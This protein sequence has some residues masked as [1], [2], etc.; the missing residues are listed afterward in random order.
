MD[1][2]DKPY[3]EADDVLALNFI[4]DP[5]RYAFRRY[6]RTGLRSHI[7]EVLRPEDLERE[8]QGVLK[9]KN[10]HFPRAVSLKMLRIFRARFRD[11]QEALDE[12]GRVK[13]I[14]RYLA[15]NHVARSD[16]FLVSYVRGDQADIVLCGLQDYVEG[17]I[18]DPWGPLD[19][20]ILGELLTRMN[21]VETQ[22]QAAI[23]SEKVNRAKREVASFIGKVRKMIAEAQHIPDLAGVGNLLLT[24]R[25]H[26][27]LV[28]INN[29]SPVSFDGA[30][31]RDDRDYPVCD[32]SIEA[33]S[34]LERNI[35][36]RSVSAEDP[37]YGI[38]LEPLRMKAVRDLVITFRTNL[39]KATYPIP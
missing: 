11:F 35:L 18:L 3:I 38:F 6:Y 21:P 2:R 24:P 34:L 36:G 14:S 27:R 30:I 20:Q 31:F 26:I 29:I 17:E 37:L 25:G 23:F 8:R 39:G 10:I 15:P 33:L 16:E 4:R 13:L 1:I 28:D 5:A 22:D 19:G 7:L 12:I 9:G 32:K